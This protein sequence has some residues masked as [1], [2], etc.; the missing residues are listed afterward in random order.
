MKSIY[1]VARRSSKPAVQPAARFEMTPSPWP[2]ARRWAR[3]GKAEADDTMTIDGHRVVGADRDERHRSDRTDQPRRS[4]AREGGIRVRRSGR[5]LIVGLT[6]ADVTT[7]P[8]GMLQPPS[9]TTP[10]RSSDSICRS[11]GKSTPFTRL[12]G[13]TGGLISWKEGELTG[14]IA[15]R[16]AQVILFD[17]LEKAASR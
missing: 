6:R 11:S 14:S 2:I 10:R 3:V 17:Q 13:F 4:P 7:A 16:P 15:R 5:F 1:Q 12:I 9:A 8:P